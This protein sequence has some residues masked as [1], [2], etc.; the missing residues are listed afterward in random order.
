MERCAVKN[1]LEVLG[2]AEV[3]DIS[4]VDSGADGVGESLP[5]GNL[6][7]STLEGIYFSLLTGSL[8]VK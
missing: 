7:L 8:G 3:D 2:S 6:V 4:S 1:P 5:L